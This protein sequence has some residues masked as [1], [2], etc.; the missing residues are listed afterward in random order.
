MRY[1]SVISFLGSI[2]WKIVPFFFLS[3]NVGV[4]VI[5]FLFC[6]VQ[7][8]MSVSVVSVPVSRF[9]SSLAFD[10]LYLFCL[11]CLV[12][13]CVY[14]YGLQNMKNYNKDKRSTMPMAMVICI[15]AAFNILTHKIVSLYLWP[16]FETME[17][18]VKSVSFWN[19]QFFGCNNRELNKWNTEKLLF[20]LRYF[21]SFLLSL[22]L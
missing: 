19:H 2:V 20:S 12:L 14:I 4:W 8:S 22:L 21:F 13:S 6:I 3:I 18:V 9:V 1:Y 7:S 17:N 10:L 15:H 5:V 16:V 11:P